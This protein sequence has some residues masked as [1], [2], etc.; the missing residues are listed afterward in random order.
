M[1]YGIPGRGLGQHTHYGTAATRAAGAVGERLTGAVLNGFADRAAI[2][3]DLRVPGH[4]INI[5]HA[6]LAG[7]RLLL[8]DSKLWQAG[9]YWS[10]GG[11]LYRGT[12]RRDTPS[13]AVAMA[14]EAFSRYLGPSVTVVRPLVV[15]WSG[16]QAGRPLVVDQFGRPLGVTA[17]FEY[18][19][20]P[21]LHLSYPG[22]KAITGNKLHPRVKRFIGCP[23]H[24]GVVGD[25]LPLLT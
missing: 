10:V 11:A 4:T 16:S 21:F 23:P 18:T 15:L 14:H 2:F 5:D 6:V 3:H 8:I 7:S 24:H 13:K 17:P 19:A 1:I 12:T 22:G 25:L 20:R 9:R